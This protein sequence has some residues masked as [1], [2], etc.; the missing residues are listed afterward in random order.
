M[1]IG[2]LYVVATPIGNLKDITLRALEILKTV[3]LVLAEDTRE[4]KK[5]LEAHSLQQ[6]IISCHEHNEESRV[7]EVV[8]RL[9]AGESIALVSDAGTPLISDPGY[10]LVEALRSRKLE[11]VPIPG[12]CALIS[13]LSVSGLPSD[14][15]Q[16]CGFLPA[17]SSNR[18]KVYES[19]SDYSG[20]TIFYESVHRITASLVDLKT[21]L[22]AD[23]EIV[24]A[25]E[26]T[27]Q[28]E[29]ILKGSVSEMLDWLEE[30]AD[31]IRGEYV[32]LI[33]GK[34]SNDEDDDKAEIGAKK[35]IVILLKVLPIKQVA[36]T[37]SEIT[38]IKKNKLYDWALEIQKGEEA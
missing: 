34:T 9:E 31:K 28:Y 5:L 37:A 12:A 33:R 25:R 14:R 23:R 30:N 17:K 35:L 29:T 3:D 18:Q 2:K 6:K 36:K 10:R 4:T 32:L 11:V 8:S 16:F 38:G 24:L 15:F 20:T 13:A 22:G 19:V 27:K 21:I 7:E 1:A 26:L